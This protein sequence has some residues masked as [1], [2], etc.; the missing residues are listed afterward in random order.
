MHQSSVPIS[1]STSYYTNSPSPPQIGEHIA[2]THDKS[3]QEQVYDLSQRL[4]QALTQP[5]S[6]IIDDY[7]Q[8]TDLS[9]L[10]LGN[11]DTTE[12][13]SSGPSVDTT[14]LIAQSSFQHSTLETHSNIL[15]L[16]R[17]QFEHINNKLDLLTRRV[18]SLEQNLA[19]DIRVILNLLQTQKLTK[20]SHSKE[21]KTFQS[22]FFSYN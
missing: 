14:K 8:R 4:E 21:V 18:Q 10:G 12:N 1:S 2:Q 7:T 15:V 20:E 17:N 22:S 13:L 9:T 11:L 16:S 3:P 19:T 6:T 5:V